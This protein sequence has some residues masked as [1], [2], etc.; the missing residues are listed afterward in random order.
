MDSQEQGQ[1]YVDKIAAARGFVPEF[2]RVMAGHD[3][4]VLTAT[5]DLTRAT[6]L[7]ER[8]LDAR[9][10]ELVFIAALVA[11]RGDA[12][13]TRTHMRIAQSMGVSPQE[14]LETLELL[15]PLGGVILF[16]EGLRIWCEATGQTGL[17]VSVPTP[18]KSPAPAA[19]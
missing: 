11:L 12:E 2:H 15:L 13:D 5:D 18:E 10:K 14:I 3:F 7:S 4:P 6:V 8:S 19:R 17:D 16:K 9:T 1:R